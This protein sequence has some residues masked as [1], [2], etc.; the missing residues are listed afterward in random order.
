MVPLDLRY[1]PAMTQDSIWFVR[2]GRGGVEAE[3][4]LDE[5]VV[6][7]GW[8]QVPLVRDLTDDE[9]ERCF[10]EAF[11]SRKLGSVRVWASQ[12]KRFERDLAVGDRVM[13]YDPA[14]RL[15]YVGAIESGV[16]WVDTSELPRV[17][18]TTWTAKLSRD[19][20]TAGTRNSL[21]SIATLFSV[22]GSTAAEVLRQAVPLSA[23]VE[24]KVAST[25]GDDSVA[26]PEEMI[27]RADVVEKA[28]SF[29][30][31][32][33]NALDWE[34]MQELVAGLLRAM[35]FKTTVA[36]RGPDRGVDIRASPDGLMLQEP[37]VFV[38]VKHRSGAMGAQAIRAF[39]G[40]RQPA[41]RCLYVSTGGFT[42]DAHYE[43]E[44][45]SVPLTLLSLPELRAL[46]VE[47][48]ER[49]D[50]ETRALIPLSRIYWPAD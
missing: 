18:R 6:A 25:P 19:V 23:E 36:A 4:F 14:Q 44:R 15:Y 49:L 27:L 24:V 48:Y 47:H 5:G 41:D 26:T 42:K 34:Q 12:V 7:I 13:T 2:A 9:V 30:E 8:R 43:A 22:T 37:R 31:D 35:G 20:L 50:T 38:E 21:G 29:I 3:R 33:L 17:R 32:R 28:E 45:S 46:V 11:P 10:V 16:K 1:A 40:G 39:V